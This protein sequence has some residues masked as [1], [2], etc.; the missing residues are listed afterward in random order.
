M[1]V[2]GYSTPSNPISKPSPLPTALF[3]SRRTFSNSSKQTP[4]RSDRHRP[5]VNVNQRHHI[6]LCYQEC[7]LLCCQPTIPPQMQRSQCDRDDR[8]KRR[9]WRM[10]SHSEDGEPASAVSAIIHRLVTSEA[11]AA[12]CQKS[13]ARCHANL[14]ASCL[15]WNC[16]SN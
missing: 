10:A 16:T 6:Y 9:Y 5:N 7:F 15:E 1:G 11:R 3:P 4:A 13:L 12:P 2:R 14:V 8:N